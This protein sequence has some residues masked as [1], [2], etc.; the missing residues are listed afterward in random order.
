MP[1]YVLEDMTMVVLFMCLVFWYGRF[2]ISCLCCVVFF[3]LMEHQNSV[4]CESTICHGSLL[5]H[6]LEGFFSLFCLCLSVYLSLSFPSC[7][8]L[9]CPFFIVP[10]L[11]RKFLHITVIEMMHCVHRFLCSILLFAL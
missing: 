1:V 7:Q 4:D 5:H 3:K 8:V 6:R 11:F 10:R 2:I 9:F